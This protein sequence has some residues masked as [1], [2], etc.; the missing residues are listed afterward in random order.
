MTI[1][2]NRILIQPTEPVRQL[3][4][5]L[6]IP[7]IAVQKPNT[8]TI[9]NVGAGADPELIGKLVMYNPITSVEINGQHLISVL[10]IKVIL[11]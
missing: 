1:L 10:E 3:P 9:V 6:W 11:Q 4:S 8:G 2:G 5:G 7:E